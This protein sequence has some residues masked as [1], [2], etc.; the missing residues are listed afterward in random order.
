[1]DF[2]RSG[3][4]ESRRKAYYL[5]AIQRASAADRETGT[6]VDGMDQARE[7]VKV[8]RRKGRNS[9][10]HPGVHKANS[11]PRDGIQARGRAALDGP[12]ILSHTRY[13][14]SRCTKPAD[15]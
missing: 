12:G 11:M 1:M 3:F 10:V 8:A 15:L 9:I 5:M 14:T 4:P 13:F 7:L 6:K 2:L